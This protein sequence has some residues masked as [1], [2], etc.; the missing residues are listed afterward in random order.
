[1]F[2]EVPSYKDI[3]KRIEIHDAT[4][5]HGFWGE[6]SF[7]SNFH[8]CVTREG[9]PSTE[10]GYMASKVLAEYRPLFK[11]MTAAQAK[12]K[13]KD[14]PLVDKTSEDWDARKLGCMEYWLEQKFDPELNPD[15]SAKLLATGNKELVEVNWWRDSFWGVDYKLGGENNLGKL[16]MKIRSTL[17]K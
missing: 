12:K 4:R 5:I 10:N 3:K 16:L 17:Q 7:L 13:W 2:N 9:Y 6:F 15:L 8:P 14:F 11:M 1:M